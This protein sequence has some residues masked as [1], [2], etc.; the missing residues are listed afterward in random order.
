MREADLGHKFSV[1]QK[2]TNYVRDELIEGTLKSGNTLPS[3]KELASRLSVSRNAVREAMQILKAT[4]VVEINQGQ[5][6]CIAKSISSPVIDS[7]IFSLILQQ[8]TP[9]N[10]LELREMLEIGVLE[11]AIKNATQRD[12][13]KMERAI[14]LMKDDNER[15]EDDRKIIAKH[16][17]AFHHAFAEATHNPL[18]VKIARTVW[19]MFATS[20]GRSSEFTLRETVQAHRSILRG[21]QQRDLEKAKAAVYKSLQEWKED[22][23]RTGLGKGR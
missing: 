3:E 2:I 19:Q 10:L 22:Q 17:L 8:G 13:V 16:D 5:R 18:I 4:G 1:V 14:G 9:Q 11:I 6:T 15:K 7:L 12:I 23:K 20:I 21:I